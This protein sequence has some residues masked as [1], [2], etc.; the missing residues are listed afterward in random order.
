MDVFSI[1][2]TA[3]ELRTGITYSEALSSSLLE[4]DKVMSDSF[5][6]AVLPEPRGYMSHVLKTY[7]IKASV[8]Q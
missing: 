4:N 5:Q 7:S 8:T 3:L 6:C 2:S 1:A